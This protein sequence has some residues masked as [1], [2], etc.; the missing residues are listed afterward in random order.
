MKSLKRR[1][2]VWLSLFFLLAVG[3]IAS[4]YFQ[5]RFILAVDPQQITCLEGRIFLVDTYKT[6]P[7]VGQI[8]AFKAPASVAPV[9]EP[10]TH[11]IKRVIAGP[12]DLVE[13]TP[14]ESITVNGVVVATGLLHLMHASDDVKQRFIGQKKLEKNQWW[15]IGDSDWSFDSRYWG[16]VK[17]DE[18]LGKAYVIF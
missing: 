14:Q 15:F 13:I 18:I 2:A 1:N 16:V 3:A 10:G 4:W 12:N 5:Q 8:F 7:K 11:M 17:S 9:Y 6:D